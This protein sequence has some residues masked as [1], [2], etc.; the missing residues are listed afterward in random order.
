[1]PNKRID[2]LDPNLNPLT[3]FELIPIFDASSNTTERITLNTLA[4]FVDATT[5]T[6]VTGATFDNSNDTLILGTNNNGFIDV[7]INR[8]DRWYVPS[9][10]TLTI[11]NGFQSFIYGD[12]LVEG[13]IDLQ[14]NGQ[15]VVLNGDILLSG[16]TIIGSGTTYS[17]DLPEFNTFVT[18]GIFDSNTKQ[19]TFTGNYGFTPFN[20]DLSSLSTDNFY[21]TGATLNGNTIEF[22]RTDLTNAYSVDLSPLKFTGNTLSECIGDIYVSNIHSCSPLYINPNNEGNVYFGSSSG[23]T[24]DVINNEVIIDGILKANNFSGTTNYIPKFSPN[25]YS[26]GNSVITNNSNNVSIGTISTPYRFYVLGINS[27]VNQPLFVVRDTGRIGINTTAPNAELTVQN[28]NPGTSQDIL[29]LRNNSTGVNTGNSI[30]F[31][32]STNASS[33]VGSKIESIITNLSGRNSINFYTHGGGG[34]YGGLEQRMSI[35]GTGSVTAREFNADVVSAT[36]YLNLPLMTFTGNTS[37]DCITDL[38]VTNLNSCS[39]LHIQPTNN[40]DVYISESGGNVGIGTNSP[41]TTL[42]VNG[43]VNISN[44]LSATT[45]YGDGSNLLG[46]N[47]SVN[48]GNV[49]F[50]DAVNGNN[51]TGV[52]NNFVRPFLSITNALSALVSSGQTNRG[53]VYVRRGTYT[54]LTLNLTNG[55][56]VYCEPGVIITGTVIIRDNGIAVTSNFLGYARITNFSAVEVFRITADSFINIEFDSIFST[57]AAFGIFCPT[58]N[59]QIII[60]GNNITGD[61]LGFGYANTIR[62]GS[63]VIM[64]ITNRIESQHISI[65][66]RRVAG[67]VVINA[68]QIVLRPGNIYGG[69]S[70]QT[71]WFGNS[72]ANPG[73]ITINA[74]LVNEDTTYYGGISSMVRFWES[75]NLNVE[76]NGSIIGGVTLGAIMSNGASNMVINGDVIS[77]LTTVYADGS[78]TLTLLNSNLSGT[79][80]VVST[81]GSARLNIKNSTIIRRSSTFSSPF[82]VAGSSTVYV[83]DST[84]YSEFFGNLLN[85]ESNTASLYTKNFTAEG[86]IDLTG[87]TGSFIN[88]GVASP[89]VGLIN[90][91]SNRDNNT[92]L[93][94]T[95]SSG[96]VVIPNLN[97]PKFF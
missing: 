25:T 46:L 37:A 69:N 42:D 49:A 97:V 84:Y 32:N 13:T 45:F 5:D 33:T 61:T 12:F 86:F 22:D 80:T 20:V 58:I 60:K 50:V 81:S 29:T 30:R 73:K 93:T 83:N 92:G 70:K 8:Y 75:P 78:S 21:T 38:Y 16:G 72:T 96:F 4:N 66:T 26:I 35:D 65:F 18:N 31:I 36:T 14:E 51:S 76:I 71:C 82:T 59:N 34:I 62:D 27:T 43:D 88:N 90:T 6:F 23:I 7:V 57:G 44:S 40:G 91:I 54:N 41:I 3:G 79:S 28:T 85:I 53:L 1:M 19:I 17:I 47:L 67:N 48:Y 63:N 56:D 95:Y 94:T 87:T 55:I 10:Q 9:G 15:L 64:N 77:P 39:P 52:I 2:Q 89:T 68:K 74:D 11:P 24:F